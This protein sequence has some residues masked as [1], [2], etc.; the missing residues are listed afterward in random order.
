MITLNEPAVELAGQKNFR[1]LG[2]LPTRDGHFIRKNLLFRS[3]SLTHLTPEDIVKLENLNLSLIIDFRSDREVEKYPTPFISTVKSIVRIGIIDAARETAMDY[4]AKNDAEGM[5]T[6]LVRDYIRLVEDHEAEFTRFLDVVSK[7][8]DL[9]LVFHCA[10][11]KDRTGLA[12]VYL[13]TALGVDFEKIREDYFLTNHYG[14]A[15]ANGLIHRMNEEG[16][17]GELIRP[18]MEV[19]QE[20]LDAALEVMNR[21]N[22]GLEGYVRDVLKAD[23]RGLQDKYLES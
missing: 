2:G 11:G 16:M 3:G 20:Y 15:Y 7:T 12:A 14:L 6:L 9:P 22:R 4:L 17:N 19:R 13:L 1:D 10:A 8:E 21:K 5:K 23:A 18:L